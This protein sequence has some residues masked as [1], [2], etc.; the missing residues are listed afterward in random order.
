[1]HYKLNFRF[2]FETANQPGFEAGSLEPKASMLTIEL[3]SIDYPILNIEIFLDS[4]SFLPIFE[5]KFDE[6]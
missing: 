6:K 4:L 5:S 3:H 1:M 2:E